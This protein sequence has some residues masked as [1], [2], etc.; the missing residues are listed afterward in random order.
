MMSILLLLLAT[1]FHSQVAS[2]SPASYE[3]VDA[4]D[5]Y[6][7][8]LP[9]EWP[10]TVAKAKRLVIRAETIPYKMCLVPEKRD[11]ALVGPAIADYVKRN[12][13]TWRLQAGFRVN[14]PFGF[15]SSEELSDLA[16]R[17]VDVYRQYPD[18]GGLIELS[19]VGFN[20]DKSIAVVYM[21]HRCGSL[22]CGGTF[23][24]LQKVHVNWVPLDWHGTSCGWAS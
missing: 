14:L 2:T 7:A 22:C 5:V 12:N 24:V 3:D 1:I 23:H 6:S 19:A 20:A 13:A 16:Q 18:S 9:T 8:I 17:R 21:G 10:V 15:I 4:Y 11:A